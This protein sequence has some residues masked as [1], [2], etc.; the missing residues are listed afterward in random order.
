[1]PLKI[2]SFQEKYGK[3]PVN[4]L[5]DKSSAPD[6]DENNEFYASYEKSNAPQED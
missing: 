5:H 6:R 1:M 4:S 2:Q 3:S